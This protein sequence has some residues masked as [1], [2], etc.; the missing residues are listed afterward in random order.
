MKLS[1]ALGIMYTYDIFIDKLKK[2]EKHFNIAFNLL[3]K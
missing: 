1:F 2:E 3:L